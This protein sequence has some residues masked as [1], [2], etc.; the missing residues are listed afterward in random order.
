MEPIKPQEQ[1]NIFDIALQGYGSI[2]GVFDI[3]EDN[4]IDILAA[5]ISVYEDYTITKQPIRG[6]I[7]NFYD[8][9]EVIPASGVSQLAFSLF[10]EPEG[11]G[12]MCVGDDFIVGVG[13]TVNIE[14]VDDDYLEE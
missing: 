14:E 6:D 7:K 9:R 3:M 8:E 5:P 10:D 13:T 4:A 2:E 11:I 1:Q 12:V